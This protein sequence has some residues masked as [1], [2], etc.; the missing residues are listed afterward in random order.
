VSRDRFRFLAIAFGIAVL[1]FLTALA[2]LD[3]HAAYRFA[4]LVWAPTGIALATLLLGGLRYWPA[5]AAGAFAANLWTG[6]PVLGAAG[7]AAGNTLEAVCGAWMLT[8]IPGFTRSL[9][10][11]ADALALLVIAGGFATMV[12]ATIGTLSLLATGTLP[13]DGFSLTW[14]DWWLG[15]L[16]GAFVVSPLLL[17]FRD[18]PGDRRPPRLVEGVALGAL[19]VA[20]TL[21][22]FSTTRAGVELLLT[23]LLVW[24]CLR[25]EQRGAARATF[26]ISAVAIW[27]TVNG[28][29]PFVRG[30]D[31]EA[32]L[33][34]LQTFMALT[35]GTFLVLGAAIAERRRVEE[36][37]AADVRALELA[38]QELRRA[39]DEAEHANRAKDQFLA[40][41]SHE[42]RTPLTPVLALASSLEVEPELTADARRRIGVVRRNTELEARLIDDLLDLTRIARGKL[43]L[44]REAVP[45]S[46]AVEHVVDICRDEAAAK[47]V[48]ITR[49][50][51]DGGVS[52]FADPARFRQILWNLVRNAV[53]FT[54]AGG[55]VVIR[56]ER[57]ALST[58]AIEV[59]D[60]GVGID[61]SELARIFRPFEQGGSRSGGLGLGLAIAGALVDA[62]QGTL[63]ASSGGPGMGSTFRVELP[64]SSPASQT[65]PEAR[66]SPAAAPARRRILLVEDHPDTLDA[67]RSL[68][69]ELGCEVFAAK[70]VSEALRVAESQRIDV[71]VSDLGL[72]DGSGVDLMRSLRDRHGLA[73]IAV[74]G[75]GMEDDIRA[76]AAAGFVEHLV[77]PITF[78]RL[79]AAID[80]FF[81]RPVPRDRTE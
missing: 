30:G 5:V 15:D 24:A 56:S 8:R 60:T 23:P 50:G 9:S 1:Y 32:S 27:T 4:S 31:L 22:L 42:L 61:R 58:V 78:Q 12:S 26:A 79:A 69:S 35:A 6:A 44:E 70:S 68:L 54:P 7:I 13:S 3:I 73:G 36:E 39:K 55:R 18:D 19:L 43:Q 57:P 52:V 47:G 48:T 10:R 33:V 40:A 80:R 16:T 29:G 51:S 66:P 67:A 17:T 20:T 72:P 64:I 71:V 74:T 63:T 49:E 81:D 38:Q 77:K 53:K 34:A 37:R 41:L 25:F 14:R 59:S 28:R 62:H 46:Q 45:L 11:V 65:E 21:Y 2:G 75:Y 76:G